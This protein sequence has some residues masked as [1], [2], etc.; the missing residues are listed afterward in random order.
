MTRAL[1]LVSGFSGPGLEW[2]CSP[3]RTR[4]AFHGWKAIYFH[5]RLP[6]GPIDAAAS[7]LANDVCDMQPDFERI[8]L[9]GHSMG[10]L[11]A[12]H[13]S[14]LHPVDAVVTIGT[15]HQGTVPQLPS[16][17]P[18]LRSVRQMATGS[19]YLSDIDVPSWTPTL[20]VR[21]RRDLIVR[22]ECSVPARK[23]DELEVDTGHLRAIFSIDVADAVFDWL[24]QS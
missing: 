4:A 6:F 9:L 16:F 24:N 8:A 5:R 21:C 22:P 3:L 15:P 14:L 11:V 7:R 13:A 2:R 20:A 19:R 12:T 10:G 1:V 18:M 23:H 17:V